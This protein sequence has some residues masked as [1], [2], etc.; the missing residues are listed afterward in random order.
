MATIVV[1]KGDNVLALPAVATFTLAERHH[2][3]RVAAARAQVRI[4][5]ETGIAPVHPN[6]PRAALPGD[7]MRL[8]GV[9]CIGVRGGV[10]G[11]I[12]GTRPG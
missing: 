2:A 11:A 4:A 8:R 3:E 5:R 10:G 1:A 6:S 7:P 12:R 9:P